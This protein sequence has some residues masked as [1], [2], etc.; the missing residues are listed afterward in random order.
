M[1]FDNN[2][3]QWKVIPLYLIHQY[4]GKN[5]KF[6]SNLQVSHLFYASL[7]NSIKRNRVNIF[8]HRLLCCQQLHV[9]LFGIT[10]IFK[11]LTKAFICIISQTV[12]YILD[13][14]FLILMGN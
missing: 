8:V 9:S 10:S 5:F 6:H 11:L 7:I 2:F 13:D 4:L 12:I 1:L 3:H 14:N